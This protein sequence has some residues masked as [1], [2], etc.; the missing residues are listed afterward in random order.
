MS[1]LLLTS[2]RARRAAGRQ[3]WAVCGVIV[4]VIV[5]VVIV[6]VHVTS[7][8]LTCPPCQPS[9]PRMG[10]VPARYICFFSQ[11][12][13]S[14]MMESERMMVMSVEIMSVAV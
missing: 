5:I 8:D 10:K 9:D 13:E 3:A 14:G 12:A 7:L 1:L 4:I 2:C 11:V 6:I